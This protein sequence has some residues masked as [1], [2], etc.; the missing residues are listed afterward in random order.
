MQVAR[1]DE[2]EV[3]AELGEEL[4]E[5]AP[6]AAIEV[7]RRHDVVALAQDRQHVVDCGHPGGEGQAVLRSLQRREVVLER[8]P[9]RVFG[10]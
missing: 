2:G 3:D 10:A 8:L 5:D 6:R 4:G 1:I 9:R 7:A